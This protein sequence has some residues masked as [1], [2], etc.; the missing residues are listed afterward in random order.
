MLFSPFQFLH[1]LTMFAAVAA[2]AAPRCCSTWWRGP[3]NVQGS[4]AS[5][6]H[7]AGEYAR[8]GA[9]HGGARL[10]SAGGGD[11]RDRLL[12]A[13]TGRVVPVPPSAGVDGGPN[14]G[15][16]TPDGAREL[17]PL[18]AV[19]LYLRCRRKKMEARP[20][21]HRGRAPN[22]RAKGR[23]AGS[24]ERARQR[25]GPAP[26]PPGVRRHPPR[27]APRQRRRTKASNR[28][29]PRQATCSG[30]PRKSPTKPAAALSDERGSYS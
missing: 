21:T 19:W 7:Q 6:R 8:A 12:R 3:V 14:R 25:R 4:S 24:W 16:A 5:R 23:V 15:S 17:T 22:L 29:S 1:V 10:R 11:R 28:G 18:R 2:V 9:L 26:M 27:S 30:S 13:V 20:L